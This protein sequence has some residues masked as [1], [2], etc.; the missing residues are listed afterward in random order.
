MSLP[1]FDYG[2]GDDEDVETPRSDSAPA[3][4]EEGALA[5][6]PPTAPAV[7]GDDAA[8]LEH[9]TPTDGGCSNSGE[10]QPPHPKPLNPYLKLCTL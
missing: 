2:G 8:G 6:A 5:A 4:V 10:P 7:R 3:L 9:M 1:I